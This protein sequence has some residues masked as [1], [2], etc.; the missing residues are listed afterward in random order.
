VDMRFEV[1]VQLEGFFFLSA[2]PFH[3][4]SLSTD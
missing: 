3:H 1:K 4:P 2:C